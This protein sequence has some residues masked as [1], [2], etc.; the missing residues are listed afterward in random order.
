V[1]FYPF[2]PS[3]GGASPSE[4]VPPSING[5]LAWNANLATCGG[6]GVQATAG[7]VILNA[8]YIPATTISNIWWYNTTAGASPTSGECQVGIYNFSGTLVASATATETATAVTTTGAA[9][10]AL[11]NPWDNNTAGF[12]WVAMVFQAET[13]PI[14][15]RNN[16]STNNI[17]NIG[18]TAATY[19]MAT[20]G[21]EI[22]SGLPSSIT[23]ADNGITA[24]V[25]YWVGLN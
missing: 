7:I 1:G 20:N 13:L 18:L 16:T 22:T 19:R 25:D 21:S 8:I 6:S 14:I 5:L 17:V 10:A 2:Q 4:S 12:Y 24:S 3:G 15:L 9:M 23:P 11:S